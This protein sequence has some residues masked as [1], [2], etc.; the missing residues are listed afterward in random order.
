MSVSGHRKRLSIPRRFIGDLLHASRHAPIVTFERRM[1]LAAVA[2]ARKA[3]AAPPAWVLLFA[4]AFAA[5]A[6][7][8]PELRQTY[9][10]TPWPHLWQADESVA[11]VAVE[12]EYRG[13]LGVFFGFLRAPDK[14]PLAD[15]AA[16]LEGWRTKP[17]EEVRPFRRQ[18][19]YA[20]VPLPARRLLWWYATAWSGKVKARNFG[21]FG[22]SL[23]GA[24]GATA[25][26][27]IGPLTTALNTGVVQDDGTVDV[28]LHF[29]HRVFDGMP[30]AR[31]LA[32]MEEYMR[33]EA[34]AELAAMAEPNREPRP[35]SGVPLRSISAELL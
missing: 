8:R 10:P 26:N 2:V 35:H 19:R 30:A 15:L 6:A 31:T 32:E 3:I 34:V 12:R 4:K 17:V 14:A 29:D 25:L 5:V 11:S 27:L 28:R 33:T 24:S 13:E 21:T 18:I 9:L 22:L 1:D 7:K 16:V 20:R 23:T